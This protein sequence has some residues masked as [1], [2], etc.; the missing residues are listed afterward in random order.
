MWG[1]RG[2][3]TCVAAEGEWMPA[4]VQYGCDFGMVTGCDAGMQS[5]DAEHT[6]WWNP[7][8][9][10][11]LNLTH[12]MQLTLLIMLTCDPCLQIPLIKVS[13]LKVLQVSQCPGEGAQWCMHQ[14]PEAQHSA[15]S[16]NL[17]MVTTLF[18]VRI[19]W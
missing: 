10:L 7:P 6:L 5:W 3:P 14:L 11:A 2:S 9:S 19:C 17:R 12:T 8:L 18:L 4:D 13:V 15:T 1:L 16:N